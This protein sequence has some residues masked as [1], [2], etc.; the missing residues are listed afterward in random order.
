MTAKKT[1]PSKPAARPTKGKSLEDFRSV[2]D[3]NYIV[4]KKIKDALT[5][6]GESWEYE[7]DFAKLADISITDLIR[8]REQFETHIVSVKINGGSSRKNVWAGTVAFASKLRDMA[9]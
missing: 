2:H 6:L 3:K 8:F 1:V 7:I 5:K 9:S 4:P